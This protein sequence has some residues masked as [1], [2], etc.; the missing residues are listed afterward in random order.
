M[1][2]LDLNYNNVKSNYSPTDRPTDMVTNKIILCIWKYTDLLLLWP[3]Y[4]VLQAYLYQA[5]SQGKAGGWE[6]RRGITGPHSTTKPGKKQK[7]P[8]T[9]A[10]LFCLGAWLQDITEKELVLAYALSP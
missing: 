7:R 8:S 5:G 6:G 9:S 2:T 1:L 4:N 10:A 3:A